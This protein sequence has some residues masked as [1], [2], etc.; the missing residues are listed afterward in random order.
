[1]FSKKKSGC[2]LLSEAEQLA[3]EFN[4][5]VREVNRL[6]RELC[7]LGASVDVRTARDIMFVARQIRA[8][9]DGL[10]SGRDVIQAEVTLNINLNDK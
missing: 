1:M 9:D 8:L 6:S 5:A 7:S 2:E 10:Y 4:I 3:K